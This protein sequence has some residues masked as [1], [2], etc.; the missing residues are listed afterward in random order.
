MEILDAYVT[1]GP[2]PQTVLDIFKDEWSSKMPDGSGLRSTPGPAALFED[3]RI[4]WL[5][6]VIGGFQDKKILELGP[7]EAGH[8]YMMHKGG[9]KSITAIEANSRSYLKCLCVKEIFGLDRAGFVYAD[10]QVYT[11]ECTEDFDLCVASGILYHMTQPVEFIK[12]IARMSKTLFIWTHYYDESLKD[13]ANLARQF[14][15]PHEIEVDGQTYTVS[16]RNYEEALKWAGFC[17]GG[18]P[19][20]HWLTRDSLMQALQLSGFDIKSISFDNQN[21]PNGPSLALVAQR[22]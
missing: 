19:W 7:L 1:S 14:E 12:N 10:A 9:A 2:N 21:H 3:G 11:S 6:G 20:A 22:K 13:R 8:T 18:K 4:D 5:S 17:G 16:K 15:E